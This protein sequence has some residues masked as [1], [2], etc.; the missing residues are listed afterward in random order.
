[1]TNKQEEQL[2]D[3]DILDQGTSWGD[4]EG[5]MDWV[6]EA[7]P[8]IQERLHIIEKFLRKHTAPDKPPVGSW[9]ADTYA[10]YQDNEPQEGRWICS[11]CG[12]VYSHQSPISERLPYLCTNTLCDLE[13][14]VEWVEPEDP[15]NPLRQDDELI[16]AREE[17]ERLT[18]Q[19]NQ[20][21]EVGHGLTR[22][23][24]KLDPDLIAAREE[25]ERLNTDNIEIDEVATKRILEIYKL[26][27][28][29]KAVENWLRA[30][31]PCTNTD[32]GSLKAVLQLFPEDVEEKT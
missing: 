12:D 19:L 18:H 15:T 26:K 31:T 29:I 5:G 9:S 4:I 20:W 6:A 7:I 27:E 16:A 30:W 8:A 14:T 32:R 1:M 24:E 10:S 17:I 3:N 23:V 13:A 22:K 11:K 21:Q 2:E 28:T 25:I